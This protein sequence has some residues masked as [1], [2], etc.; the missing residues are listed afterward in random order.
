MLIQLCLE[1]DEL[2]VMVFNI[3]LPPKHG[4]SLWSYW[5]MYN[6]NIYMVFIYLFSYAQNS[7]HFLIYI[8][9]HVYTYFLSYYPTRFTIFNRLVQLFEPVLYTEPN[10]SNNVNF[11]VLSH[12]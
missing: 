10:I 12:L 4:Q 7:L 11:V 5:D 3:K 2:Y 1:P 8:V 6:I 9:T